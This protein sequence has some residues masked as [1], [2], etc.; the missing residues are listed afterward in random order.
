VLRI[1][2]KSTGHTS[3]LRNSFL[4]RRSRDDLTL[5]YG[6]TVENVSRCLEFPGM[7]RIDSAVEGTDRS[8]ILGER[9]RS[10]LC[11]DPLR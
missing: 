1:V 6:G 7:R 2:Q 3:A 11:P 10:T 9:K 4:F 5:E 8:I